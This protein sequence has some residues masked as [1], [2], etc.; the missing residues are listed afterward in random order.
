[1]VDRWVKETVPCKF[2][3][4]EKVQLL[5][6]LHKEVIIAGRKEILSNAISIYVKSVL[7]AIN[8]NDPSLMKFYKDEL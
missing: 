6:L 3:H 5:A 1:M 4:E 8:D 7:D 2:E